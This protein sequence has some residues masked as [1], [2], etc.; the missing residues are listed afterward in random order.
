MA[1][2]VT[3]LR[4]AEQEQRFDGD[5]DILLVLRNVR[6]EYNCKAAELD[7]KAYGDNR[8]KI[9][10]AAAAYRQA[11]DNVQ[12]LIDP[13]AEQRAEVY[14][15]GIKNGTMMPQDVR[16]AEGLPAEAVSA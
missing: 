8:A 15:L 5:G 12:R 13:T 11:A 6:D 7:E 14:D 2:K 4:A 1:H 10:A 16:V 9:Q 3:A